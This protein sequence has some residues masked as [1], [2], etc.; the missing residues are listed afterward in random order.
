MH[1]PSTGNLGS[2][3]VAEQGDILMKRLQELERALSAQE[4]WMLGR[5]IPEARVLAEIVSLLAVA[6][7]ELDQ[8]LVQYCGRPP[9][10]SAAP[11]DAAVPSPEGADPTRLSR[12]R[13]IASQLLQMLG[14]A[15]P[16]TINFARQ[17]YPFAQHYGL[18]A[19]GLDTLVIVSD[20]LQEAYEA[21]SAPAQ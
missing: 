1:H 19:A 13:A 4:W 21:L 3:I 10:R 17:L 16:P 11:G 15:L 8:L 18:P 7:A 2:D 5:D 12:Q 14:L 6:R 20:R 9:T